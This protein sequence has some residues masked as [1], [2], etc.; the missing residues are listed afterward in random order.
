M[1]AGSS[2]VL[3]TA[4]SGFIGRALVSRLVVHSHETAR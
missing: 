3:V 4:A 2:N 1:R